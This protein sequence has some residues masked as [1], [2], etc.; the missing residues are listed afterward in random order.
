M[1]KLISSLIVV[2][3]LFNFISANI[4]YAEYKIDTLEEAKGAESKR[5]KTSLEGTMSEDNA[6]PSNSAAT[7]ILEEGEVSRTTGG[8]DKTSTSVESAGVTILGTVLGVLALVVDILAFQV[9]LILGQLTYTKEY[10]STG[11]SSGELV[12]FFSLERTFFNRIPLFDINYF[13]MRDSLLG[14]SSAKETYIVGTEGSDTA[15]EIEVSRSINDI[16]YQVAVVFQITRIIALAIGMLVLI[17]V[18]IRMALSSVAE[19][20]ARYKQM[21]ISWVESIVL[22]FIMIYI[23]NAIIYV[24]NSLT[25][26]LYNLEQSILDNGTRKG[27]EDTIRDQILTSITEL[28]GM[29][30]TIWSIMY[31]CLLF[32]QIKFFLQY[33]KR[34]LMVGFLIVISPLITI[35]Y[36]L[37]K[38][39]DGKAQSFWVWFREFTANV[40]IQPLHALIYLVFILTANEIAKQAPLLA[41]AFLLSLGVVEKM[42]KAI[43]NLNGLVTLKGLTE[44][45]L[46]K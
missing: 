25:N 2:I 33:L 20:Q 10:T 12:Y 1:K 13:D 3:L 26:F 4:S 23:M 17:Y 36:A 30:L 31:W 35:T 45:K 21:L 40:L 41:L 16:K 34:V 44:M 24:G 22:L 15:R 8:S 18:G 46:K 32:T 43:F 5:E 28:A 11:S 6:A 9:D 27:F 19:D 29:Q 39:G 14:S 42:I 37:D 38:V 7:G